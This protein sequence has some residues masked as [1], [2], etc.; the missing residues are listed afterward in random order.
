MI[1]AALPGNEQERLSVLFEHNILDTLPEKE[2]DDITRIASE[3]CNTPIS[4][5]SII[6]STRQWFKSRQGLD[7]PETPRELAFCAHAILTPDE[8][9]EVPNSLE[10]ERFHD[11]PLAT[12]APH[13]VFYAGVPLVTEEGMPLG[14]LCVIDNKPK[15]LTEDQRTTLRALGNQV[16][17]MLELHRKTQALD[18]A[19]QELEHINIE[20]DKFAKLTASDLKSPIGTIVDLSKL[21]AE[22][23]GNAVDDEGLRMLRQIRSCGNNVRRMINDTL[24]HARI[25]YGSGLKKEQF[26]FSQLM[27]DLR[28][29]LS[30]PAH[31]KLRFTSDS[32]ILYSS[33]TILLQILVH[34]AENAI[35]FSDKPDSIVSVE[36]SQDERNY[37]FAVE[38]NGMGIKPEA[39]ERVFE[40]Y[41]AEP[42]AE[43]HSGIGLYTVRNLVE[44]MGGEIGLESREGRGSRFSFSVRK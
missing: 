13:V 10:D 28:S 4:L 42:D 24:S 16:A 31:I 32:T 26:S 38:D 1:S 21:I 43:T 5:V 9:F 20:L 18:R 12:G 22:K 6:D 15:T 11:N 40:L 8:I 35:R 25:A 23:Y 34:L 2:F 3:I 17:R 29:M 7:A 30:F 14:T 41:H 44:K 37:R 36:F 33:R 19:R 27:S 39:Y